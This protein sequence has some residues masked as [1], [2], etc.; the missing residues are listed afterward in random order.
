[1]P[2]VRMPGQPG[3]PSGG[4]GPGHRTHGIDNHFHLLVLYRNASGDRPCPVSAPCGAPSPPRPPSGPPPLLRPPASKQHGP[5][6]RHLLRL[7][8]EAR[9]PE[10]RRV[11]GISP[12][13]TGAVRR[14]RSDWS[15]PPGTRIEAAVSRAPVSGVRDAVERLRSRPLTFRDERGTTAA[16]RTPRVPPRAA[17]PLQDPEPLRTLESFPCDGEREG[18]RRPSIGEAPGAKCAAAVPRS[19]GSAHAYPR[20][21][22]EAVLGLRGADL[23]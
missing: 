14:S 23:P 16:R 12:A 8:A 22:V 5:P 7:P 4:R 21:P 19:D 2:S 17:R 6:P 3:E 18:A 20:P 10:S 15:R 11:R 9:G 1:M 13:R